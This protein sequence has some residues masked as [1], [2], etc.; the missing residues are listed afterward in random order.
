MFARQWVGGLLAVVGILAGAAA[1]QAGDTIRLGLPA[2]DDA[3]AIRLG[4]VSPDA[5]LLDARYVRYGGYGGYGGYRGYGGY[6]GYRSYGYGGYGGYRGYGYGGYRG[7]GYGGYRGYGYGGYS[8]G[9]R[10]YSGGFYGGFSGGYYGGYRGYG[11]GGYRGYGYGGSGYYG[12]SEPVPSGPA[13][14]S[15]NIVPGVVQGSE[16]PTPYLPSDPQPAPRPLPNDGT[17]D[18]DGG[19]RSPVPLPKADQPNN[20]PPTVPLEGR[21]VSLPGRSTPKYTYPA[22]GE[23]PRPPASGNDRGLLTRDETRRVQR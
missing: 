20:K 19:P 22:Y 10:G 13:V 18:Y 14:Y 9:Y 17:F 1:V 12:I 16:R 4:E 15:L 21:P 11:Y 23:V 6:G 2:Q 8:G 3:P 5:E 7:Y